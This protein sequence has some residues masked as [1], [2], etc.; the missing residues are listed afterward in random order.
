MTA[1][2]QCGESVGGAAPPPT[3]TEKPKTFEFSESYRFRTAS[4]TK[5]I[6]H[7]DKLVIEKH[8]PS[9][10]MKD[11]L[12]ETMV[13]DSS[14]LYPYSTIMSATTKKKPNYFNSFMLGLLLL[15]L[16]VGAEVSLKTIIF[17]PFVIKYLIESEIRLVIM[18]QPLYKKSCSK[19][20]GKE[21]TDELAKHG[22]L[23]Q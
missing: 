14:L 9:K 17:L 15:A 20:G 10:K 19:S 5:Y 18:N 22:V 4:I 23:I 13:L 3:V 12:K 21:L 11:V 1:C 8:V 6:F 7:P 16:S 2:W